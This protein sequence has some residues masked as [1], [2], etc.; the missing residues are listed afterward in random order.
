[1]IN[2]FRSCVIR[3]YLDARNKIS[4]AEFNKLVELHCDFR[5]VRIRRKSISRYQD[6]GVN[7]AVPCN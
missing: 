7:F 6:Q 1:M 4:G 3:K 2:F 5:S